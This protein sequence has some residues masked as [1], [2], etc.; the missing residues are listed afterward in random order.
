MPLITTRSPQNNV[1]SEDDPIYGEWQKVMSRRHT[2]T[3]NGSEN[4]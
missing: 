2:G 4:P 3:Y 1:K